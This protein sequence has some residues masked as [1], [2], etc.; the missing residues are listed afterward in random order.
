MLE[1]VDVGVDVIWKRVTL[2]ERIADAALIY[3]DYMPGAQEADLVDR[4]FGLGTNL[5]T[6]LSVTGTVSD[7]QNPL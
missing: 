1:T 6:N 2:A 3:A 5:G 4:A 7:P